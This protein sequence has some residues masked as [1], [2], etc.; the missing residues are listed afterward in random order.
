MSAPATLHIAQPENVEFS[1][2]TLA[3]ERELRHELNRAR[4]ALLE[5]VERVTFEVNSLPGASL[6]PRQCATGALCYVQGLA[7]EGLERVP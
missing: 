5:I 3:E 7:M 4:Q 1:G 2:M 6:T